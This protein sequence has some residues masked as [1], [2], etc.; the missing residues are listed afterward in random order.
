MSSWE[1]LSSGDVDQSGVRR[2]RYCKGIMQGEEAQSN[3]SVQHGDQAK[4]ADS[5]RC[6]ER[7]G[8]IPFPPYPSVTDSTP[9]SKTGWKYMQGIAWRDTAHTS[10]GETYIRKMMVCGL[11]YAAPHTQYTNSNIA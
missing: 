4:V 7:E 5:H 10:M 8:G 11:P 3:H 9:S 2:V 6:L 1:R